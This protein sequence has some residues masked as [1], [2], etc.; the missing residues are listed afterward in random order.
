M[1]KLIFFGEGSS[2]CS[3]SSSSSSSCEIVKTKSNPT[4]SHQLKLVGVVSWTWVGLGFDKNFLV[5]YLR[6]S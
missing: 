3:S 5:N 4:V 6:L 1:Q 2:S